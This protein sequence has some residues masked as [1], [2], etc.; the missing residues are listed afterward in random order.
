MTK[1]IFFLS[2]V[3]IFSFAWLRLTCADTLYLKNGRSIEGLIKNE[4]AEG[5]ELDVGFGTIKF[6]RDEIERIRKSSLEETSDIYQK[7][8]KKRIANK[9]R[10]EARKLIE[11]E[12][13]KPKSVNLQYE[14]GQIM[15]EAL[16]NKRIRSTLLLDTGASI[17][18]LSRQI[19]QQ[20]GPSPVRRRQKVELQLA[21]GRKIKADYV[22]LESLSVQG[23]EAND[24]AAAVL[25]EDIGDIAYKDGLL[26]MSFLK[27]FNFKIDQ[28]N[29]KLILE[30]V[31]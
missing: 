2:V 6:S 21:D 24:V 18:L 15:V 29:N 7:W 14:K 25:S 11:S 9:E 17:V 13:P 16:L 4:S 1:Y 30:K 12:N 23:V 20:I 28:K 10:E 22:I 19:G 26:G 8:E 31:Q 27:N 5:L 3:L